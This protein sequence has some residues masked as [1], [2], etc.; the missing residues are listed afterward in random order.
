MARF[1]TSRQHFY[2]VA[3]NTLFLLNDKNLR[4]RILETTFIL[5]H[6]KNILP[7]GPNR[8]LTNDGSEFKKRKKLFANL[9]QKEMKTERQKLNLTTKRRGG[10]TEERRGGEA[11]KRCCQIPSIDSIALAGIFVI[12]SSRHLVTN[13]LDK[14]RNLQ[15]ILTNEAATLNIQEHKRI[16]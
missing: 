11:E 10:I 4:T 8:I 9:F 12:H 2:H 14:S 16:I 15:Q 1:A 13:T 5:Y 6:E 7:L 3:E